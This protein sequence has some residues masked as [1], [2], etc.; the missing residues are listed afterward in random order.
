[1]R[2]I[3]LLYADR[4]FMQVIAYFIYFDIYVELKYTNGVFYNH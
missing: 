3:F 2:L 4:K 1:M